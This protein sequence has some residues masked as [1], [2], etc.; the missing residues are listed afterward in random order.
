MCQFF[1]H[2]WTWTVLPPPTFASQLPQAWLSIE[3]W[4]PTSTTSSCSCTA[5]L[6]LQSSQETACLVFRA[7][8]CRVPLPRVPWPPWWPAARSWARWRWWWVRGRSRSGRPC[9][10]SRRPW[11]GSRSGTARPCTGTRWRSRRRRR[12]FLGE[13]SFSKFMYVLAMLCCLLLWIIRFLWWAILPHFF[14]FDFCWISTLPTQNYI[15]S[16]PA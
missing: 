12:I 4:K 3:T 14:G 10:S 5:P 6:Y 16:R 2:S 15:P 11:C 1:R 9:W 7:K 13:K 8:R